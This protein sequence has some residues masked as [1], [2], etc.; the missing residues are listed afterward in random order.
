MKYKWLWLSVLLFS[1]SWP[2]W[3]E[4]KTL[5]LPPA[6][7]AQWYKPLNKRQLWLHN[8]FKLR[9]EM[10]AVSWYVAQE[11]AE[12]LQKWAD[13]LVAHYRKI[14]EMVPEWRDELELEWAGRL[15]QAAAM[16]D[17]NAVSRA[18]RKLGGSCRGCHREYRAVA[19]ML[20]RSP[21]FSAVQV[22]D[23]ETLEEVAYKKAMARLSTLVNRVKIASEDGQTSLALESLTELKRR[24]DDLAVSCASCHKEPVPRERILGQQTGR[25]VEDLAQAIQAKDRKK[26]GMALGTLAVEACARCHGVHRTQYDMQRLL[27]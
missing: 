27:K 17:F 12:L 5:Q 8:M 18:V 4:E 26:T 9:R 24:M 25:L 6:S 15:Q 2:S 1:F 13:R 16:A 23:S 20:Y 7:L 10:Q 21:D 3:A 14:G 19:A 22:E 11:D